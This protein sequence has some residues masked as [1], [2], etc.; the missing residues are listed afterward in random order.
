MRVSGGGSSGG[1]AHAH[2]GNLQ[3]AGNNTKNTFHTAVVM[4]PTLP[5]HAL[6]LDT[7]PPSPL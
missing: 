5:A 3:C 6:Q 4:L 2:K 1:K 7:D